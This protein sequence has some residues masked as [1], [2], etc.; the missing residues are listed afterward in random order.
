MAWVISPGSP[1]SAGTGA[2]IFEAGPKGRP[3][4]P[5]GV[6]FDVRFFEIMPIP[7]ESE[8]PW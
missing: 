7:Q 1:L 2:F 6:F 4:L 3:A 5:G 8:I